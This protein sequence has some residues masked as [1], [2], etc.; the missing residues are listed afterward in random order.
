MDIVGRSGSG[1]AFPSQ[2]TYLAHD[3]GIDAEKTQKA[4]L[5]V[6]QWREKGELLFPDFSAETIAQ[7][8]NQIEYLPPES[9]L[10]KKRK[11]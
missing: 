5:Q 6:R 1:F 9:A 3:A 2:T 11:E 8:N 10:G 7:I 4:I